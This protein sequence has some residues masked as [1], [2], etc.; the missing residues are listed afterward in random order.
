M[1]CRA[2]NVE[3]SDY[4]STLKDSQGDGYF[5]LCLECL[6]ATR[7]AVFDSE[8]KGEYNVTKEYQGSSEEP[9]D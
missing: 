4:E 3:L 9:E 5:D 7:Q 8:L 2:C 6:T 1:R